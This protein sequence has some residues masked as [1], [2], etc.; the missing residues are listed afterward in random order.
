M[1]ALFQYQADEVNMA[2]API[3]IRFPT[4]VM[5]PSIDVCGPMVSISKLSEV[6]FQNF[7]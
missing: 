3:A 6:T 4:Q 7:V 5:S 2:N 1:R